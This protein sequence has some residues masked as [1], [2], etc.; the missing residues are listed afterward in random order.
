MKTA[1][2]VPL[3]PSLS[4]GEPFPV[5]S[6]SSPVIVLKGAPGAVL[7]TIQVIRGNVPPDWRVQWQSLLARALGTPFQSPRWLS[8]WQSHI[9]ASLGAEP[10]TVFCFHR[11]ELA[12]VLPFSRHVI[13]GCHHLTWRGHEINDYGTPV[14]LADVARLLDQGE[15]TALLTM[16]A[17][18]VGGIDLVHLTKQPTTFS[19]IDNPFVLPGSLL[20]HAGA[21]RIILGNDWT[22]YYNSRRSGKSRRRLRE[23]S[24][25]LQKI[26]PVSL[27]FAKNGREKAELVDQCI[28]LKIRQIER[29]GHWNPFHG[30][31]VRTLL[32]A[33]AY[34][35]KKDGVWAVSL[36]VGG[37]SAAIAFGFT[38]CGGWLLYQM[39][40]TEGPAAQHSPGIHLLHH[41]MQHC[42]SLGEPCLDL[43]LGDEPY[44][45][46]WCNEHVSLM[47]ST[48]AL[49]P[50]GRL[51]EAAIRARS[52][53][54]LKIRKNP[55]AYDLGQKAKALRQR[56]GAWMTNKEKT[57]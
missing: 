11:G 30:E 22:T 27:R 36:D 48:V 12:A 10:I 13:W 20:Y 38:G 23:K 18:A 47:T 43:S 39:A 44:K 3:E 7:D 8:D 29:L 35:D 2:K 33:H 15:T 41:L 17:K 6:R 56:A 46:D 25:A 19:G 57:T 24:A 4:A 54:L 34:E 14:I 45:I 28:A 42:I 16:A 52:T 31:R 5:V 55:I 21:H 26:G 40:M 50:I 51:A 37:T 49:S 1:P 32:T 9:G 53:L